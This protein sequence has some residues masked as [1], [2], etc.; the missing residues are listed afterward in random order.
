M[1]QKNI[2]G[3]SSNLSDPKLVKPDCSNNLGRNQQTVGQ[4]DGVRRSIANRNSDTFPADK[5]RNLI[6][7]RGHDTLRS[8]NGQHDASD[9]VPE[10]PATDVWGTPQCY[11]GSISAGLH[12]LEWQQKQKDVARHSLSQQYLSVSLSVQMRCVHA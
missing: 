3:I 7:A 4:N 1:K 2:K 12:G 11:Q 5:C 10:E 8:Q 6:A 9:S